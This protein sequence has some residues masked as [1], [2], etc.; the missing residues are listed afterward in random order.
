M[1]V[2]RNKSDIFKVYQAG[3]EPDMEMYSVLYDLHD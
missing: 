2:L 3:N 1:K